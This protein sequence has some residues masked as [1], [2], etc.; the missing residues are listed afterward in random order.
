MKMGLMALETQIGLIL[1]LQVVGHCPVGIMTDSTV[2]HYRSM[3]KNER[4]L[5]TGMAVKAEIIEPLIGL[6][7]ADHGTVIGVAVAA[8]HFTFLHRMVR[9]IVHF[10]PFQLVTLVTEF[11]FGLFQ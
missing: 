2:F 7:V 8:D 3:F 5:V 6:Q 10:C 4:S 1:F 11:R 9:R